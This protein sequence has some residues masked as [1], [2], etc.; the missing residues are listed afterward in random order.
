MCE[1]YPD[2][3][4]AVRYHA[5]WPSNNDPYWRFNEEENEDRIYYY[6]PHIDGYY[7]TPYAWIDGDVRGGYSHST[8]ET[9]ILNEMN[10]ASPLE[11]G[12]S[13]S[14]DP[15]TRNGDLEITVTATDQI[16]YSNLKLR[17]AITE[18][19]IYWHA[20][21]GTDWHH[22]TFRDM[23]PSTSGISLSIEEG[24]TLTF[25]ESFYLSRLLVD[26]NCEIVVFVQSD[27]GRRILQ[28]AKVDLISLFPE[29]LVPFSL[30]WP[31]DGEIINTCYPEFVW[32]STYE[33]GWDGEVD[34]VVSV[35]VDPSFPEPSTIMSDPI[36][37]TTWECSV[38][39]AYDVLYYWRVLASNG[40]APDIYSNEVFTFTVVHPAE[41]VYAPGDC[42]HNGVPLELGD[43]IAMIGMYRGT[44]E[45]LYTCDCPPHSADFAP[46]AD[47]NGNCVAFELGDV[48]TEIAAYRGAGSASGC[49]DCPGSL[50]LLPVEDTPSLVPRLKSK[51][52]IGDKG[53][54]E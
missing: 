12:I 3:F 51:A 44:V 38:C 21:N 36:P 24:Q 19:N 2:N 28:G 23:I 54:S 20:P 5:W 34:Y 1:T 52:K 22:Q 43:V 49:E 6:P 4:V 13:G 31:E 29:G 16:N 53:V 46:E 35:C 8:W 40:H 33:P 42:N 45:P 26:H 18:S 25:N 10:V 11:I 9:L 14:Y 15:V 32:H 47:P 39:L 37:D 48:V 17:I 30:I 50:R 27:N 7:Y 41:C